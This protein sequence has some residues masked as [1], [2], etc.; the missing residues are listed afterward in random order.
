MKN[1]H[2]CTALITGS[3]SGLGH[4]FARQLAPDAAT[5]ILAARRGDRLEKLAAEL[6]RPGLQIVVRAVDLGN[7]DALGAFLGEL[8]DA[9]WE[10]DLLI[11][12]AGLGDHGDF[13]EAGWERTRAMLEVNVTA[14]TRLTHALLPAMRARRRG[15]ILNVS[16]I[17]SLLP[18]P[19]LAVYAAT[20]AYVTSFSEAIRAE[21][22]GSGVTVTTV[23]PGPVA[24]EFGAVATRAGQPDAFDSPTF[25]QVHVAEAARAGLHAAARDRARV[26]PGWQV[27][28]VMTVAAAIPMWL[29]RQAMS[30]R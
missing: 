30:R 12:N 17:A 18:V 2:G 14:L 28:L 3:S 29:L 16:S 22:R 26:I 7:D 13:V 1:W 15:T 5:L 11:N 9:G 27:A 6:A 24:T 4:E 21:L 10:I 19:K 20:K 23:C 25:F 8:N